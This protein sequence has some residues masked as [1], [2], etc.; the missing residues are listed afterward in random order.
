MESVF[1]KTTKYGGTVDFGG[2]YGFSK[3][4]PTLNE[5][6]REET[7]KTITD[8]MSRKVLGIRQYTVRTKQ[9]EG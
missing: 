3:T 7:D 9:I 2:K 6:T 1:L 4:K 5:V 8:L